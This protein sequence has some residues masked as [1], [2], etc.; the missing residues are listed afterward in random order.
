MV[1]GAGKQAAVQAL[2]AQDRQLTA[3]RAVQGC[4][5]VELWL[6]PEDEAHG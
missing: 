5:D 2:L 4:T 6:A 3:W 1:A